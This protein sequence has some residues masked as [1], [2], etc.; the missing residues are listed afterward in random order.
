MYVNCFTTDLRCFSKCT[1]C[2]KWKRSIR[3]YIRMSIRIVFLL[4]I[5]DKAA[6]LICRINC[7]FIVFCKSFTEVLCFLPDGTNDDIATEF[8]CFCAPEL[9]TVVTNSWII[10]QT[11][12]E[13]WLAFPGVQCTTSHPSCRASLALWMWKQVW[14]QDSEGPSPAL[15]SLLPTC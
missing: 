2:I 9:Q 5:S 10:K 8:G 7:T 11:R 6:V 13:R 3:H 12:Q 15:P 14:W 4:F 1:L